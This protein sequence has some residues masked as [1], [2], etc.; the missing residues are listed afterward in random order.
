MGRVTF[1]GVPNLKKLSAE[2]AKGATIA[3]TSLDRHWK[4]LGDLCLKLEE[5]LD[6]GVKTNVYLTAAHTTGFPP[7]YDTHDI[8][9]LQ[10]AGRKRWRIHEPPSSCRYQSTMRTPELQSRRS[11]TEVELRAGDCCICRAATGMRRRHPIVTPRTSRLAS[12][13][14]PGR[15]C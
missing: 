11:L 10:I 5:Q 6:H 14:T 13:C 1:I 8:L 12:M 15:A 4:P 7:H 2:Y 3:L 9:V